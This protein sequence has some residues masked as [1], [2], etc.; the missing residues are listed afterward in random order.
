MSLTVVWI[1]RENAKLFQ[2]SSEKMERKHVEERHADHHTHRNEAIVQQLHERVFFSKV[3]PHLNESSEVLI[4]G[5]GVAKH[6]FQ[7][8]LNEHFPAIARKVVGCETVDHP[9][10]P[11]IA[12]MARKFFCADVGSVSKTR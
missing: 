5:P 4:L 3:V 8:H 7:N 10:D 11:E 6:H 9:T 12:A 1:D 2:F